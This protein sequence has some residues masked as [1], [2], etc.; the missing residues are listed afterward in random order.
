MRS[1]RN[2][3]AGTRTGARFGSRMRNVLGVGSAFAIAD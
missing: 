3:A 2:V 1:G